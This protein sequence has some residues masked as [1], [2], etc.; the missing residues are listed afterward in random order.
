M[1]LSDEIDR[2]IDRIERRLGP[3]PV[4]S[5]AERIE[6]HLVTIERILGKLEQ[7]RN[8]Q[9]HDEKQL[10]E[11]LKRNLAA[12]KSAPD[13]TALDHLEADF[14]S[15]LPGR[16]DL[17]TIYMAVTEEYFIEVLLDNLKSIEDFSKQR[18]LSDYESRMMQEIE[19]QLE[20]SQ[21]A[22]REYNSELSVR[23]G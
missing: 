20:K 11:K 17:L 3:M 1:S 4:P 15:L 22:L 18:S 23:R 5:Y 12:L 19:K 10:L 8:I 9:A 13:A 7:Y 2:E 14:W 21:E 16:A 6:E